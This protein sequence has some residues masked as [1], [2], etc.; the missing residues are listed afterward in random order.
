MGKK[1]HTLNLRKGT[2]WSP[3]LG[4]RVGW[5]LLSQPQHLVCIDLWHCLVTM[6]HSHW[7]PSGETVVVGER[8]AWLPWNALIYL[9]SSMLTLHQIQVHQNLAQI[10][11]WKSEWLGLTTGNQVN[12]R[13]LRPMFTLAFM[14]SVTDSFSFFYG[15]GRY[16][17]SMAYNFLKTFWEVDAEEVKTQ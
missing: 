4:S 7:R 13:C 1:M 12:Y 6:A 17:F 14:Q 16:L 2:L 11:I 5:Q 8:A 15:Q 10:S 3:S 9:L